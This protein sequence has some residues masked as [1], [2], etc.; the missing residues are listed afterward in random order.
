MPIETKVDPERKVRDVEELIQCSSR[1]AVD[2]ED[3]VNRI[4]AVCRRLKGPHPKEASCG[5]DSKES[6][7]ELGQLRHQLDRIRYHVNDLTNAAVEL[8]GI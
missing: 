6:E 5:A 7:S 8:E 2:I 4:E 3:L 1:L